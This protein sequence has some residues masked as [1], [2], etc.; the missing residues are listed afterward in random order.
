MLQTARAHPA[1][2]RRGAQYAGLGAGGDWAAIRRPSSSSAPRSSRGRITGTRV[3]TWRGR[4]SEPASTTKPWTPIGWSQRV[5]QR[6]AG[7][8]SNWGELYLR[9]RKFAEALEQF[10]QALALDPSDRGGPE[11]IAKSRYEDRLPARC[12]TEGRKPARPAGSS[13][14]SRCPTFTLRSLDGKTWTLGGSCGQGGGDQLVG[15][16][17]RPVPRGASR[18]SEAL[19]EVAGSQRCRGDQ[20]QRR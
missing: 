10:D 15:H 6:R 17:V 7:S 11:E 14:A 18:I 8:R 1:G 20:F 9:Q 19:R 3:T 2:S 13:R 12:Q 5:P 4:W 16:M